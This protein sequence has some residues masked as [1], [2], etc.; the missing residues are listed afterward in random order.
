VYGFVRRNAWVSLSVLAKRTFDPS[1][2]DACFRSTRTGDGDQFERV[3]CCQ[4]VWETDCVLPNCGGGRANL[5]VA[6]RV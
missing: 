1:R 3:G 4:R 2:A 6:I 5:G